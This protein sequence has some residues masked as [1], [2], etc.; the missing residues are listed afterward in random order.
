MSEKELATRQSGEV[1][2]TEREPELV[3]RPPTDIFE[4]AEGITLQLDMPGVSRERLNVQADRQ[5]LVVEGNAEISMPEGMEALYA[6]VHST[7]YRRSFTLSSELETDKIDANLK[8]GVLT[9]RI[10][11]RAELRPRK[12][13]IRVG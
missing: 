3:L 8:D 9:V 4:D 2:K 7:L 6:E 5:A 13:D 12:I 1:R 10:P 11:K